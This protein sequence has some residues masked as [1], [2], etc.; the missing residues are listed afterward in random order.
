MTLSF[1]TPRRL[2]PAHVGHPLNPA[3]LIVMV[4][5]RLIVA[6]QSVGRPALA[7]IHESPRSAL[8]SKRAEGDELE[9]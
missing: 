8:P 3:S 6:P 9:G 2:S 7:S 4:A 1:T 5:A